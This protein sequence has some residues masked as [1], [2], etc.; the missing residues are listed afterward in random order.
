MRPS[1]RWVVE[2]GA[3]GAVMLTARASFADHYRVPTG[4]ME[5][6]VHVDD[7]VLVEKAAY[8]LRVPLTTTWL[9]RY[10]GP[11]RGDVVIV[12]TGEP[13]VLLKR[14]AAIGGDVV[15]VRGGRVFLNGAPAEDPN[16][17]LEAGGGPDFGPERVPEGAVF[18]LGD[19][20]GDS[21]DG[22]F[23]GFVAESR[24]LGRARAVVARDGRPSYEPL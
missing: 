2:A 21:R 7:H 8:G 6:T 22:R 13:V 15:A 17:G 20:R 11:R 9:L 3:F 1:L 12:D 4:S 16:A 14:V 10:G 5:P 23:F 19:N 18:V 24:V